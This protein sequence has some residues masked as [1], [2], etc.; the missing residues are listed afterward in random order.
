VPILTTREYAGSRWVPA[1]NPDDPYESQELE[2]PPENADPAPV[3]EYPARPLRD[4][5]F[6][7]S[8]KDRDLPEG[9]HT[10]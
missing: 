6:G 2:E 5:L 3:E 1:A 4:F 9:W 8:R 10:S 7:R